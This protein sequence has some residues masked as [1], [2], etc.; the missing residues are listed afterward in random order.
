MN[1]SRFRSLWLLSSLLF[2]NAGCRT[3]EDSLGSPTRPEEKSLTPEATVNISTNKPVASPGKPQP[4]P[5]VLPAHFQATVYEV[6]AYSNRL[7]SIDG[8]S[9]AKQAGSADSL[10]KALSVYGPAKVL[11]RFDQPVNVFSESLTLG[12][13]EPV[14]TG[15]RVSQRGEAINTVAYQQVGAMIRLSARIPP[16]ETRRKGPD[17]TLFAELAVL[18]HSDVEMVPGMKATF[19]RNLSLEHTEELAYGQPRVL[20]AVS[21]TSSDEKQP[22]ALYVIRYLF[23]H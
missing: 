8:R 5:N 3:P 13:R 23:N 20:L 21:S 7:N 10:L 14:V 1:A 19:T 9:L 4:S 18:G 17:V 11:Y 15:S 22:P 6:Q 12:S 16:K 2:V